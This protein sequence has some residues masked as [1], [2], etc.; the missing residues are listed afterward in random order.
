MVRYTILPGNSPPSVPSIGYLPGF[1]LV[2]YPQG[3]LLYTREKGVGMGRGPGVQGV[4]GTQEYRK[5][6]EYG[7]GW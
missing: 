1:H 2:F 3:Y 5:Y 4:Q 7:I 6:R